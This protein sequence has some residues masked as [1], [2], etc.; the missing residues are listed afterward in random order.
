MVIALGL[1]SIACSDDQ[2]GN[3]EAGETSDSNTAGDGDGDQEPADFGPVRGDLEITEIEISQALVQSVFEGGATVPAQSYAIPLIKNRYTIFRAL[4]DTP[5][6]WTPRPLIARLRVELP[7]GTV[8]EFDDYQSSLGTPA[9]VDK[10][11][12]ASNLFSSFF[13]RLDPEYVVPGMRYQVSIWEAEPAD[14]IPASSL[15]NVYPAEPAPLE[16]EPDDSQLRIALVGVRYDANGC[17]SDT[18]N[19]SEEHFEALRAGFEAW[20]G[21]ETDAVIIDTGVAIDI[22]YAL[23]GVQNLLGVVGQIRAQFAEEIPDAFFYILWDDCSPYAQGILGIAPVNNDP[24]QITDAATRYAAGLWNANDVRESVNTA[25]HEIGHNQGAPHA[26]CG[27]GG[28]TD[29]AYPHAGASIGI[30]GLDPL[31]GQMYS[32]NNYTDFMSY[33]RPYWVSDYRWAKSFNHQKIITSWGAGN[34][35]SEARPEARPEAQVMPGYAGAVLVGLVL[36]D[37][38]TQWWI[39]SRPTPPEVTVSG[40]LQVELELAGAPTPVAARILDLPDLPGAK[41]V[42]VPLVEEIDSE[43]ITGVRVHG[44][45]IDVVQASPA[46]VDHRGLKIHGKPFATIQAP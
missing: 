33:C 37:G 43:A 40:E 42:E 34:M 5:E 4:W 32:P 10:S 22:D 1:G 41:L 45:G 28:G 25:V 24:P 15:A 46:I 27:V 21:V 31:D 7:D 3:G 11:S 2:A 17:V 16:I 26:P 19:L 6:G 13:W 12:T 39:N 44:G 14:S 35:A 36:P 18:S 23:S 8:A 29:P 20:N 38:E 9:E 30:R